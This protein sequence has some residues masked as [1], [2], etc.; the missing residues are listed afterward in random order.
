[1][2]ETDGE[3]ETLWEEKKEKSIDKDE[4]GLIND[5]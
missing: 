4:R 2:K 3:T 1:M 5:H